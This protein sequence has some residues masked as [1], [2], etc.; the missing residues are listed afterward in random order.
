MINPKSEDLEKEIGRNT[1][2]ITKNNMFNPTE[3]S[4]KEREK[5]MGKDEDRIQELEDEIVKISFECDTVQHKIDDKDLVKR[6]EEKSLRTK[7]EF[8]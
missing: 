7:Q 4:A 1:R 5:E 3:E 6:E 2:I 8:S